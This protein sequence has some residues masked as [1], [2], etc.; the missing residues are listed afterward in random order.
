MRKPMRL[1]TLCVVLLSTA[2][3][4]AEPAARSGP[5][6]I[7]LGVDGMDP[8]LLREYIGQGRMPNLAKLAALGGFTELRTSTPPQSPVAWSNFITGM[9]SGTHGIF[10]FLHLDRQTLTPYSSTARVERA[11]RDPIALG[12]W[13]IPIASEKT[14]QLRD[15]P[16]FWQLLEARGVPPRCSRSLRTIRRCMRGTQSPVWAHRI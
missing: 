3:W 11:K 16:A 7:I 13:R 14:L 10:D 5:K 12:Q 6:M 8:K 2:V 9:D 15:G 1:L 4:G